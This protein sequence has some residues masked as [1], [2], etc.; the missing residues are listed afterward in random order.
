[1]ALADIGRGEQLLPRPD[2]AGRVVRA[3]EQV[4]AHVAV[5]EGPVERLGIQVV[6]AV[7]LAP[8]RRLD[9]PPPGEPDPVK[10]RLVDR[11][12]DHYPDPGGVTAWITSAIPVMTSGIA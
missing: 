9:D 5:R 10:E 7:L 11:G 8:Q 4:G 1:M 3:A 2:P 6:P 12:V